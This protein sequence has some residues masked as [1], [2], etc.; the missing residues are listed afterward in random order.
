VSAGS[1]ETRSAAEAI[2]LAR[3]R[4]A[5]DVT[6]EFLRRHPDWVDRYGDRARARGIE[7]ARFHV[8]FLAGAI[9]AGSPEPFAAYVRWAARLLLARR[10][11]PVFLVENLRQIGDAL[12]VRLEGEAAG[13][14]LRTVDAGIAAASEPPEVTGPAAEGS[15]LAAREVFTQAALAGDR[16]AAFN[17]AREAVR[18]GHS[19]TDVYV[20]LL[21][22]SQREVG[23]LW[24]SNRVTVAQEHVATAVT[25]YVVARLYDLLDRGADRRGP[26]VVTG[27][28]GELHQL[29]GH[30]VADLLEADGWDVRFLGT[31][32]P[33]DG[34]LRIVEEHRPRLVG[35]SA[36][37]LFNLPKVVALIE[38]LRAARGPALRIVVGGGLFRSQPGLW[39]EIGADGFASD[40]RGVVPLVRS[41]AEAREA[42]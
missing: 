20:D 42:P 14:V 6:E 40:L 30:M 13:L 3:D 17:V 15:L 32:V 7:D 23:R 41:I 22:T 18:E 9:E 33:R 39:R 11:A 36:M 26:A 24:E 27:I 31:N 28:E 8:D 4:V 29:G 25:Q 16:V 37:M 10:I 35:I 12:R 34:V 2:R 1:R 5:E 38:S 21:E 19:V